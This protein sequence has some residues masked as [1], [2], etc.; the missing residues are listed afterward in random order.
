[1][2]LRAHSRLLIYFALPRQYFSCQWYRF[3][4]IFFFNDIRC[5]GF[6]DNREYHGNLE[7]ISL[8]IYSRLIP[9][10]IPSEN[11]IAFRK[12]VALV[13]DITHDVERFVKVLFGVPRKELVTVFCIFIMSLRSLPSR[14]KSDNLNL[15]WFENKCKLIYRI[16][17]IRFFAI[18]R[19]SIS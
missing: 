8:V 7:F 13:K 12:I 16:F 1:M 15:N 14:I 10:L 19:N 4:L 3:F 5:V 2:Y 17:S 11:F 9:L 6:R 18:A